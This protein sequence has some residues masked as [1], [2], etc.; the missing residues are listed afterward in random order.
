MQI[1]LKRVLILKKTIKYTLKVRELFKYFGHK[2]L[3]ENNLKNYKSFKILGNL[4]ELSKTMS[5]KNQC[6]SSQKDFSLLFQC[7]TGA[8]R[9][10]SFTD[11]EYLV[12][13]TIVET[14]TLNSG[15][16]EPMW[17]IIYH[18]MIHAPQLGNSTGHPVAT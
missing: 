18:V 10:R 14:T 13:Y 7:K 6:L 11:Y 4:L 5:F 1:L 17:S 3:K 9:T 12:F 16:H 15:V 8:T 2:R